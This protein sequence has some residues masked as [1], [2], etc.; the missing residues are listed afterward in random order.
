MARRIKS[1]LWM[2]AGDMIKLVARFGQTLDAIELF[3]AKAELIP[4][5]SSQS[6]VSI[7]NGA[8]SSVAQCKI[9]PTQAKC[10]LHLTDFRDFKLKKY[11]PT[12][13][14][15]QQRINASS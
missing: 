14:F 5:D 1:I 8:R 6:I 7:H 10:K 13:E 9:W 2:A 12:I 15:D 11:Y 3:K 4:R